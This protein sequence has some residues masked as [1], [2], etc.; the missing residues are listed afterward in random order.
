[1]DNE[2]SQPEEFGD[3]VESFEVDVLV[4]VFQPKLLPRPP[5]HHRLVVNSRKVLKKRFSFNVVRAGER[6]QKL[7][8]FEF[9]LHRQ[10]QYIKNQLCVSLSIGICY[11][12]FCQMVYFLTE[13]WYIL[14][15]LGMGN[16]GICTYFTALYIFYSNLVY[17]VVIWYISPFLL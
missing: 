1:L 8:A 5:V 14:E 3:L 15:G 7:P 13:L 17:F 4:E 12:Q 2:D 11:E 16:N 10:F 9:V 6:T